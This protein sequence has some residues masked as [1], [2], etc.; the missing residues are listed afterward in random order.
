MNRFLYSPYLLTKLSIYS[1]LERII[2][3][4]G[5]AYLWSTC[6]NTM[7]RRKPPAPYLTNDP[8]KNAA[9]AHRE[10]L[11]YSSP[12]TISHCRQTCLSIACNDIA[13]AT[14]FRTWCHTADELIY[15]QWWDS[16]CYSPRNMTRKIFCCKTWFQLGMELKKLQKQGRDE[17]TQEDYPTSAVYFC[18]CTCRVVF[19]CSFISALFLYFFSAPSLVEI[20]FY[21]N[22]FS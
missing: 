15:R 5:C 13:F 12:N 8:W 6:M 21:K 7:Q 11:F 20:K 18:R 14:H 17:R 19:L 16:L 4:C 2:Q 3:V 9:Y 10:I 1:A 22:F